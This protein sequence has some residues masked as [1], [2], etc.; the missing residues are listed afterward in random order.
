MLF[1]IPALYRHFWTDYFRIGGIPVSAKCYYLFLAL[2]ALLYIFSPL[3]LIPEF[4]FGIVGLIDDIL[5]FVTMVV[6]IAQQY[7]AYVVNA[8]AG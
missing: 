1:D 7:R 6:Y 8:G 3:D 4:M 5:V 2:L